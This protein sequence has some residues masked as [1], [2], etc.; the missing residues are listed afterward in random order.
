MKWAEVIAAH[1][2]P[3][4]PYMIRAITLS[5]YKR[6]I[7]FSSKKAARTRVENMMH[8]ECWCFWERNKTLEKKN[9][10][11]SF[12]PQIYSKANKEY[13][14]REQYHHA[15]EFWSQKDIFIIL[16]CMVSEQKRCIILYSSP[17]DNPYH[18]RILRP[19]SRAMIVDR[20]G[21][22]FKQ[23]GRQNRSQ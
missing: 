12:H 4:E 22:H 15:Q 18:F 11:I 14:I 2:V 23:Q 17:K 7:L 19:Q 13:R 8:M 10:R 6:Q 3:E 9:T 21:L 5:L 20:A 16:W 1:A